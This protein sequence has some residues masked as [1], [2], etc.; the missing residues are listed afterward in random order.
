M[1]VLSPPNGS[2]P[3]VPFV[4]WLAHNARP[5]SCAKVAMYR[6]TLSEQ[7]VDSIVSIFTD[8][9]DITACLSNLGE[10]GAVLQTLPRF[11]K[12]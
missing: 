5:T 7:L 6:S 11:L 9:V 1:E 12:Q 10:M 8:G 3:F 4:K 2:C